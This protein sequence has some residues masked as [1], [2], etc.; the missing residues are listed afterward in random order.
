MF[1]IR[2]IEKSTGKKLMNEHGFYFDETARVLQYRYKYNKTM[3]SYAP[4]PIPSEDKF[5]VVWSDWQDVPVIYA[6]KE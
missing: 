4:N 1:D 2:W 5:E 6:E 3:Y